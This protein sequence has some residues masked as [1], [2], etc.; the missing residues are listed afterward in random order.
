MKTFKIFKTLYSVSEGFPLLL[1]ATIF[2]YPKDAVL[3]ALQFSLV[4]VKYFHLPTH[5]KFFLFRDFQKVVIVALCVFSSFAKTITPLVP[6]SKRCTVKISSYLSCKIFFNEISFPSLSGMLNKPDGL[7]IAIKKSFS[8]IIIK[9]HQNNI[10][11]LRNHQ[12]LK[13]FVQIFFFIKL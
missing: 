12:S 4:Q 2:P 7:F 1:S 8:K 6:L 5:N 11:L 10:I 13:Y 9:L 3:L